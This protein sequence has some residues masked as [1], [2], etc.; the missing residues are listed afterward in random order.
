MKIITR[1][2]LLILTLTVIIYFIWK[3]YGIK[4]PNSYIGVNMKCKFC[5]ENIGT[6]SHSLDK[7]TYN[8]K[9]DNM[10]LSGKEC[11]FCKQHLDSLHTHYP[12]N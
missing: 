8:T 12:I 1:N 2:Y 9:Y 3:K 5:H 10:A 11:V 6:H 4:S 7:S